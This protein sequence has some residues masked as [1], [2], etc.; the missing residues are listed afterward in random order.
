MLTHL[1]SAPTCCCPKAGDVGS[2]RL[3]KPKLQLLPNCGDLQF[4]YNPSGINI[5][6]IHEHFLV[7]VVCFS[8][9]L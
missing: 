7:D 1:A 8:R 5:K 6:A 2:W 4:V 9:G 3:L